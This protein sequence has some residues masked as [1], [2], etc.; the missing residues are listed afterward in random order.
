M[1][2]GAKHLRRRF[3]LG[4]D[5]KKEIL[6]AGAAALAL[7]GHADAQDATADD[8]ATKLERIVITTPLRRESSLERSTSSVTVVGP[9]EIAQSPALD[10]P[11]LLKT[12]PGI[13]ATATGGLG[14]DSSISLRGATPSQTLVLVNGVRAA[15]ATTGTVNLSSIPLA[16]IER[17]E[18]AKGSHSAQYGADAVGGIINIITKQGGLCDDGRSACGSI[19]AG[20]THPWGGY[21][22]A[23]VQGQSAGGVN[24]ALGGQFLG[25]RGYDFTLP[26]AWGHEPDDDGF[27]RGSANFAL[28]KDLDWGRVYADGLYAR[29]RVA[30]DGTPPAANEADTDNFSGRLGARIDHSESWSSTLEFSAALDDA[31]NFRGDIKGDDFDTRR[32]GVLAT[33]QKSF[34]TDAVRHV[35][36][37]GVEAYRESVAGSSI[38]DV[39]YDKTSRDLTAVF[40]QYSFEYGALDFDSGLRYDHDGQFGGATTYNVGASYAL[41]DTLVARASM[42]TGFRAPTFN[43]L[44]YPDAFTPGNPDLKPEK[45]RSYEIGLTWQP[46]GATSLDLALYRNDVSNQITWA[47]VDPN[48]F[49]GP[50]HPD[51]VQKVRVTGFEAALSHR[52]SEQWSARATL[53]LRE[54]LN[55]SDGPH[56]RYVAYADRFKASAE[57]AYS[58]TEQLQLSGR[59]LY[60][61]AR[62]TDEYNTV[63]LPHYVTADFTALYA[64]DSR[65]QLKFSVENLFDEQYETKAGYR[66]PGRT[67]DLSFT[68]AF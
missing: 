38:F 18:I 68:R 47:P 34:D 29:G 10:L 48:D 44:Y 16:S 27:L 13:T 25:T 30:Y 51:N 50:W 41:T 33:T 31:A 61:A 32:Y 56:G 20:V 65:S 1:N 39:P 9:E 2:L 43:D 54:P 4:A 40:G 42:G 60:G 59:V 66:A 45:S 67:L 46:T 62:Y 23:G 49:F 6:L 3:L 17:I 5:V 11:S 57:L 26:S 19:T 37:G 55:R 36:L 24:Y 52:F 63:E 28:S 35:L 7:T 21:V 14:A 58:P 8:G 53:D 64:L 12:V 22:S 15:S